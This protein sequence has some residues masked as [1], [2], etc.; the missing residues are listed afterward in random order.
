MVGDERVE[1]GT[2]GE[3]MRVERMEGNTRVGMVAE[4][5]RG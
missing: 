5:V 4:V 2:R 1:Q 3:E